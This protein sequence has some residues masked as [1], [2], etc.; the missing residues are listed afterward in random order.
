MR[1]CTETGSCEM[2]THS[3]LL[4]M[5]GILLPLMPPLQVLHARTG[6][7]QVHVVLI[8]GLQEPGWQCF[9]TL[10]SAVCFSCCP[11]TPREWCD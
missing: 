2:R 4:L 6:P 11:S 8:G 1:V 10:S 9:S 3:R 7:P 5:V